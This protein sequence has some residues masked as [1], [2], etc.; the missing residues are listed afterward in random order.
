MIWWLTK[1]SRARSESLAIAELEHRHDWLRS[2]SWQ[3]GKD[4]RLT[5]TFEIEHL[6]QWIAMTIVYPSFFPDMPPQVMPQEDIRLSGHQYGAGGE[7]CL[8][9]RPDNWDPSF[10]GAMMIE[11]AR[12]LLEGEEPS[13]GVQANVPNAHSVTIGQEVRGT[14]LRILIPTDFAD[15]LAALG[16]SASCPL[17]ISEQF[18]QQHWLAFPRRLGIEDAPLWTCRP[19]VPSY[20]L[21][22]GL[23]IKLDPKFKSDISANYDALAAIAQAVG[24]ERFSELL[25]NSSDQAVIL[26]ACAGDIHLLWLS[27]GSGKRTLY[28][29]AA[30]PMPVE[31]VRL[32]G[33]YDRLGSVSIAIIGCGSVGSK[34]AASLARAGV[35]RFVLVDGDILFPGNLVRNDL[36]WGTVALNKPDAV[37]ERIQD[38]DASANVSTF[39]IVLGGQESSALTDAALAEVGKC[40]LIVDATADPQTFNLCAAVSRTEKKTLVWGEVFAGGIGGLVARLR[41]GFEP[42]PHAARRQILTW[43]ADRGRKPPEGETFQYGLALSEASPP[44]IADDADVTLIAAHMVRL[45]L[46]ALTRAESAFPHAA[47]AIGLKKGWIF[48]APFDAWPIDLRPEGVWGSEKDER[49]EEELT[50]LTAQLFP[51]AGRTKSE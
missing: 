4:A 7:L 19:D 41:P 27:N 28:R 24:D 51:E 49:L 21:R 12:R 36:D 30:L 16:D 5:A 18:V 17:Q 13:E 34:I 2:V 10:T 48:E 25:S 37:A 26:I 22:L 42:V 44:L 47:Y 35:R 39:R 40:D 32:P 23:A 6:G 14:K 20:Q 29:Y 50:A 31:G 11:S 46:D 45:A 8:E 38:I 33:D 43:C 3:I 15:A 1:P 9:H